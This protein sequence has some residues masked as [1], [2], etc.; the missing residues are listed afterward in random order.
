MY[1]IPNTGIFFVVRA[2]DSG[3]SES[4][5]PIV[6]KTPLAYLPISLRYC[7]TLVGLFLKM[8]RLN[9]PVARG[10]LLRLIFIDYRVHE[11]RRGVVRDRLVICL[12]SHLVFDNAE[13]K[14][15]QCQKW[16]HLM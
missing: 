1:R 4:L 16:S 13:G 10:V 9:A 2:I 3:N 15:Y 5:L 11:M 14:W 8:K 7:V 12:A 6:V